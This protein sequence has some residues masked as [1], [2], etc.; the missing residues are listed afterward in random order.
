MKKTHK[1]GAFVDPVS[2]LM[3]RFEVAIEHG[4]R[5]LPYRSRIL[6]GLDC[7]DKAEP[8]YRKYT[9]SNALKALL[10]EGR[11]IALGG[12]PKR[13]GALVDERANRL[14]RELDQ[15]EYIGEFHRLAKLAVSSAVNA[16]T[17][18]FTPHW[19]S[20][21]QCTAALY[22]RQVVNEATHNGMGWQLKLL[23]GYLRQELDKALQYDLPELEGEPN[24][25]TQGTI[26][27]G[28]AYEK[29]REIL[30]DFENLRAPTKMKAQ[31]T[32]NQ[33]QENTEAFDWVVFAERID[34]ERP[35]RKVKYPIDRLCA[36][37]F[38]HASDIVEGW[39]D[40]V[41]PRPSRAKT[42]KIGWIGEPG[43]GR[44]D[45]SD[46]IGAK[47]KA[48]PPWLPTQPKVGDKV[49]TCCPI[50]EEASVCRNW[51]GR[52]DEV[53]KVAYASPTSITLEG[54]PRPFTMRKSGA[55]V[56]EGY[57]TKNGPYLEP[58]SK[59]TVAGKGDNSGLARIIDELETGEALGMEYMLGF[60]YGPDHGYFD[61]SKEL[62]KHFSPVRTYEVD[63]FG[64]KSNLLVDAGAGAGV[65]IIAGLE[66]VSKE[67][68]LRLIA[69]LNRARDLFAHNYKVPVL[70]YI[71]DSLREDSV[72]YSADLFSHRSFAVKL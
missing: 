9:K 71:P 21:Y 55:W 27:R 70:L 8:A 14:G 28:Q 38:G 6:F 66:N 1:V 54:H 4:L 33:F 59:S 12:K 50:G 10:K 43:G 42:P 60:V 47:M 53:C 16:L 31:W 72:M 23:D 61:L 56:M 19:N 40:D 2:T 13:L 17:V 57:T 35:G 64:V 18:K 20:Y 51:N 65:L 67:E 15:P 29:L 25:V 69:G 63:V 39:I 5:L 48:A 34:K 46:A 26:I 36:L 3:T 30:E 37:R 7:A 44:N 22:A 32:Q 49:R 52:L 68:G 58:L 11:Q 62:S 41:I 45:F 24:D